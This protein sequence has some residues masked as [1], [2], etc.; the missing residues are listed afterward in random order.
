VITATFVGYQIAGLA[1]AVVGTISVFTPSFII[2][3][4]TIP[5]FDRLQHST[6]FRRAVRGA[7]QSFVGLLL[8]TAIRFGI[9]ATWSLPALLLAL[10]AFLALRSKTNMAW[11]VLVGGIIS[12]VAF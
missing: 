1:G 6:L 4:A 9:A 2:L 7:L 5:C 8:S 10:F 3:A 12:A 11:I